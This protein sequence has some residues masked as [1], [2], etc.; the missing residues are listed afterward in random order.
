MQKFIPIGDFPGLEDSVTYEELI[1]VDCLHINMN[2][3]ETLICVPQFSDF[4]IESSDSKNM[5]NA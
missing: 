4:Y 5:L 1:C 2:I 3:Q